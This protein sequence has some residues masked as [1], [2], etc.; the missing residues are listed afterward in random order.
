MTNTQK[1]TLVSFKERP[2]YFRRQVEDAASQYHAAVAQIA[3]VMQEAWLNPFCDKHGLAFEPS[4]FTF[5]FRDCSVKG[6]PAELPNE[7][8]ES[9]EFEALYQT[10]MIQVPGLEAGNCL[11]SL[12]QPYP[13]VDKQKGLVEQFDEFLEPIT[14]KDMYSAQEIAAALEVLA[15]QWRA[16]GNND[17]S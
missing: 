16:G 12:M 11:F 4:T 6:R 3:M 15:Q 9:P 17:N 10:L 8:D 1:H 2:D 5:A 14:G 13:A 7:L